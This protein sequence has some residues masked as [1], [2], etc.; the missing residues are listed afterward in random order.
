MLM[1]TVRSRGGGVLVV[2]VEG[3]GLVQVLLG[4]ADLEAAVCAGVM[5]IICGFCAA[6]TSAGMVR[7]CLLEL[8]G[9]VA[10]RA[11]RRCEQTFFVYARFC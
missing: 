10:G 7:V 4:G 3:V 9:E 2:G 8:L 11:V 1:H 5:A 6:M